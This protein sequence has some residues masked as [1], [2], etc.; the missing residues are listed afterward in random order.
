MSSSN[1]KKI[2]EFILKHPLQKGVSLGY[3]IPLIIKEFDL[4]EIT[5]SDLLTDFNSKKTEKFL[6]VLKVKS[7]IRNEIV[8]EGLDIKVIPRS[9][10]INLARNDVVAFE[11]KC[12]Q[13]LNELNDV[14]KGRTF[15]L[16]I[17]Y[18]FKLLAIETETTTVTGDNGIDLIGYGKE[19]PP[20]NIKPLYFI[21]C[22]YYS[23]AIDVNIPKK[24][25]SDVLYN[26]FDIDSDVKHPI[27]PVLVH[28]NKTTTS[29]TNF[30]NSYGIKILSFTDLLI[31]TA[32]KTENL[33]F[34]S[35]LKD[36]N[37]SQ[38][39]SRKTEAC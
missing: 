16:I 34:D 29:S 10:S 22:K 24:L 27:I 32:E 15:E 36:A 19:I 37:L 39:K 2:A 35:M 21:Q 5:A 13:M 30:S 4:D 11:R 26:L 8:D 23:G 3:F 1:N 12:H 33:N 31:L 7:P 28:S 18:L 17:Q 9:E 25:A 20:L 14:E 38:I 6:E